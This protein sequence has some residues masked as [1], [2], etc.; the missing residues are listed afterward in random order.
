M[1]I[2]LPPVLVLF[3]GIPLTGWA[4]GHMHDDLDVRLDPD[5]HVLQGHATLRFT[6]LPDHGTIRVQVH[7]DFTVE[8]IQVNGDP[9]DFWE[10][11]I[12][13]QNSPS[14][15]VRQRVIRIE[16]SDE[17]VRRPPVTLRLSYHGQMHD[18][19]RAAPGLRFVR[20]DYTAGYIDPEGVY[21]PGESRWH[22]QV[23]NTLATYTLSVTLPAGWESVTS[24]RERS[25]TMTDGL[26]TTV[27]EVETP[28]DALTLAA[29][30][31]VKAQRVWRD[32][33]IA[34]YLFPEHA[35]LA[36]QY[37]QATQRYLEVYTRLLGPYP[38]PKFAV[39]ENF[40]PSGLGFPSFT[41]LGHRVIQRGYTQPYAL[42]HEIVHSWFGNSV[43]N[44]VTQGNW[45]EGLT[46]YLAN[47]LYEERFGTPSKA[48]RLRQRMVHEYSLYASPD[49]EYPLT[50]FHYKERP[51]D[52]AIGYQKAAMVFHMLRREIGDEAFFRG[53]RMLV[54][55]WTGRQ[56]A[57]SDLQQ[58]FERASGEDLTWFIKQWVQRPGAPQIT[59][60]RPTVQAE[61]SGDSPRGVWVQ[62]PFV[63]S[64]PPYRVRTDV[65]FLLS[66]NRVIRVPVTLTR[67][68]Q[69][70][71]VWMPEPPRRL[72]LH[73][74][75]HYTL[76][77]I[78]RRR[79]SLSYS[80]R[81]S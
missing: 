12:E 2:V 44:A 71:A 18:P 69:T 17:E 49:L 75:L 50:Q 34:A 3:L 47:Y 9:L 73:P 58:V 15:E 22:P 80:P 35:S 28:L 46:T 33:E 42:G 67:G 79:R 64:R 24:G 14:G 45:V 39:V 4:M 48:R 20:P 56:A 53:V 81:R 74:A 63:Q 72:R 76:L 40:F 11:T 5:Q 30:R 70:L 6:E 29:N 51:L 36:E 38:F 32:I 57:W 16:L 13:T 7:A 23:P 61:P 78:R 68:R 66:A 27:W 21:L 60:A 1:R 41:L 54:E 59:I 19:P 37:L 31:F 10:E 62:L 8:E 25:R 52:N 43:F 77:P 65:E 26:F 55:E